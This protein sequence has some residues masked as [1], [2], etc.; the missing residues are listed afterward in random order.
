VLKVPIASV[1]SHFTQENDIFGHSFIL[2]LEWIEG[3][4]FWLLHIFDNHQEPLALGLKVQADG[5]LYVHHH[6]RGSIVFLLI[7]TSLGQSLG[8]HNLKQHFALVAYEAV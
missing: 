3:E 7:T 1:E 8:R 5:P 6:D 4:S 2:E